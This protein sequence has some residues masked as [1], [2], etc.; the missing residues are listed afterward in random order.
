MTWNVFYSYSHRDQELRDRLAV[1]LAPLKRQ[2]KINEWHDRKIE[3][4]VN[5]DKE[6]NS[7]LERANL[8]LLLVNP[9]FLA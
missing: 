9:D 2:R 1:A 8:I 6:I 5:W 7:E 4:G 3:P